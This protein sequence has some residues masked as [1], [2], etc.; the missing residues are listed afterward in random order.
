MPEIVAQCRKYPIPYLNTLRDHSIS[1]FI[2]KNTVLLH[3]RNIP[4]LN[5]LKPY[6][7]SIDE[8][9]PILIHGRSTLLGSG[10]E[11]A[12]I[13]YPNTWKVLN[14]PPQTDQFRLL[15][16]TTLLQRFSLRDW[17]QPFRMQ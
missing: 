2:T 14:P 8:T 4:Y 7:K 1:L 9:Y 11:S 12:A 10:H 15:I 13:A 3:Y 16:L 6:P 17:R 5:T